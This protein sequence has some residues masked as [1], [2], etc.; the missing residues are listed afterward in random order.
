MENLDIYNPRD[1]KPLNR[2]TSNLI[3]VITSGTSPHTQTLVF[4]PLRGRACICVK[5]S[6][7]CLFLHPVVFTALQCIV[8]NKGITQLYL[9]PTHEPYLP[10]LP[11]PYSLPV[12]V[13]P[14]SLAARSWTMPLS[15]S[16]IS[17]LVGRPT[18]YQFFGFCLVNNH[19]IF[20][21]PVLNVAKLLT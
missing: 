11:K 8:C 2:L 10:L 5:L 13:T 21:S 3:G 7:S 20:Q 19:F 4:L 14:R 17:N 9:S 16:G 1:R 18:K 6:S 12:T 15:G